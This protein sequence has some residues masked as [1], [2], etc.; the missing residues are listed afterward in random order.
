MDPSSSSHDVTRLLVEW[1]QG[2][3]GA[4]DELLPM[5]Y[6]PLRRLAERQLRHE[7][8]GHTLRPT[9]LINELYLLL[10]QQRAATWN[11]RAHF[12]ALAA[13]LMRRILVDHAR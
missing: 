9:A 8:T 4:L 5:V 10:I 12:F 3:D 11:N 1:R 7:R 6:E 2:R 13:Q